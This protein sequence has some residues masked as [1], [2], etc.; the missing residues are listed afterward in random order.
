VDPAARDNDAIQSASVNGRVQVVKLF[1]GSPKIPL[2]VKN[3]YSADN[4]PHRLIT[5]SL[6]E[7]V[8]AGK[9]NNQ[10]RELLLTKFFWWSRLEL[11]RKV[12]SS[13]IMRMDSNTDPFEINLSMARR[14]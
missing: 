2:V 12:S 5:S 1:L 3:K 4:I 13:K 14:Q 7:L 11:Y 10:V 6:E 9:D 8:K